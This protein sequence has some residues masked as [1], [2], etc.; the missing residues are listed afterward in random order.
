M[1]GSSISRQ[2]LVPREGLC[3]PC[4][5]AAADVGSSGLSHLSLTLGPCA[6]DQPTPQ[7]LPGLQPLCS[8][9]GGWG[10]VGCA[11][12]YNR[13]SPS[14]DPLALGRKTQ[15]LV[16]TF[17]LLQSPP[18]SSEAHPDEVL[19]SAAPSPATLFSEPETATQTWTATDPDFLFSLPVFAMPSAQ[20]A[21]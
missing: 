16:L 19:R 18:A 6:L 3:G 11:V 8:V 7:P 14:L 21:I 13:C 2:E 15:A 9:F 17:T 5:P 1:S 20:S 10:G 4:L 12:L